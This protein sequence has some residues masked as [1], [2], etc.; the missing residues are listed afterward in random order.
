[1]EGILAV[2]RVTIKNYLFGQQFEKMSEALDWGKGCLAWVVRFVSIDYEFNSIDSFLI[3]LVSNFN[4]MLCGNI[5]SPECS[6]PYS[7]MTNSNVCHGNEEQQKREVWKPV[8]SIY[9]FS[10]FVLIER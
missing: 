4:V 3:C 9:S 8:I 7:Y 6:S 5:S 10:G 2:A 1:M